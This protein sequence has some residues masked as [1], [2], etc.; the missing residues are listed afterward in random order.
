MVIEHG[1]DG[2]EDGSH[3]EEKEKEEVGMVTQLHKLQE[4]LV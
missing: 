3:G 4:S 2:D 1:K